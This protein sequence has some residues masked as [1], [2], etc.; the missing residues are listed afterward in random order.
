MNRTAIEGVERGEGTASLLCVLAEER[1][2]VSRTGTV[3]FD[4][5]ASLL[6]V[7]RPC[8]GEASEMK[9]DYLVDDGVERRSRE[10]GVV[11]RAEV[12]GNRP[13]D[14]VEAKHLFYEEAESRLGVEEERA[15]RVYWLLVSLGRVSTPTEHDRKRK[16]GENT[17]NTLLA[18][19]ISPSPQNLY[20]AALPPSPAV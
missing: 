5:E 10:G 16:R 18:S 7:M 14:E 4:G 17:C 13:Y 15:D 6:V 20:G 2:S 11:K 12:S 19:L 9:R 8:V 1:V 3:Y